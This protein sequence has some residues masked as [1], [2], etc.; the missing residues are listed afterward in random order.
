MI[1]GWSGDDYIVLFDRDAL[2]F[3]QAYGWA[4]L[5]PGYRLVGMLGWDDF[6]V[7]DSAGRQFTVPTVP[8]LARDLRPVD[9]QGLASLVTD[10][11]V[12]GKVKWYIKPVIFGG[13]PTL[14]E[15]VTWITF[16]QHAE[17]VKW[18]NNKYRE[19]AS[20]TSE[21]PAA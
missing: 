7:E 12:S 5:L 9:L 11:R 17:L 10:P 8:V 15:N 20:G 14:G 19:I 21:G 16:K 2:G 1:E 13:D 18:W 4:A 6:I 3:E